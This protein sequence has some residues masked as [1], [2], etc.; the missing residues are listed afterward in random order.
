MRSISPR[1]ALLAG[2]VAVVPAGCAK[3]HLTN[4]W[5]NPQS[6]ALQN[7]LVVSLERDAELRRMWED[8]LSAEFQ[9]SG[10]MARPGYVLFPTS[11]P[12]S[13]QVVTVAHH[14]GYD[15]VVVTHR[16]SVTHT[17]RF[18]S[19]YAKSAPT[20]SSS[21]WKGWY[22]THYLQATQSASGGED[23]A[24]FQIDVANAAGGGTL[25][26]TGS[27]TPLKA[28]DEEKVRVEVGGQLVSELIRQG[29]VA[30][31]N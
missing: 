29:L 17:G 2:L 20:G 25:L 23:D 22:H 30:K 11:L 1:T 26:W 16:L 12:D 8:A 28:Y 10:V 14:D 21:Y 19:D 6:T 9:A 7:I 27:T 24:R 15:G 3:T 31:R 13:Q 5:K 18:D 4:L